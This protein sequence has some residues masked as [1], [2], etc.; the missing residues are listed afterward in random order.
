LQY[1]SLVLLSTIRLFLLTKVNNLES[2]IEKGHKLLASC[3]KNAANEVRWLTTNRR[4]NTLDNLPSPDKHDFW[5]LFEEIDNYRNEDSTPDAIKT[6]LSKY[7]TIFSNAYFDK[8]GKRKRRTT[9]DRGENKGQLQELEV[10][11]IDDEVR[12]TEIRPTLEKSNSI[13]QWQREENISSP[14]DAA[15][16]IVAINERTTNN[17]Q[18]NAILAHRFADQLKVRQQS[19]PCDYQGLTTFEMQ[20]FVE[21]CLKQT[22]CTIAEVLLCSITFGKTTKQLDI[23]LAD[24]TANE[25]IRLTKDYF[26]YQVFHKLPS[27]TLSADKDFMLHDV[28]H[29]FAI[30]CPRFGSNNTE[31]SISNDVVYR[32]FISQF[33]KSKGT[34]ITLGRI[35]RYKKEWLTQQGNDDTLIALLHN[36]AVSA[37]SGLSYSRFNIAELQSVHESFINHL[38]QQTPQAQLTLADNR[39]IGTRLAINDSVLSAGL[40]L[41]SGNIINLSKISIYHPLLHTEYTSYI[42]YML[43]LTTGYRP[44]NGIFGTINDFDLITGTIWISDK[45]SRQGLAARI[46]YLPKQAIQQ[47]EYYQ[48]YLQTLLS[49]YRYEKPT[50][51]Q[52]CQQ[53][54]SGEGNLLFGRYSNDQDYQTTLDL[55]QNEIHK[56][57]AVKQAQ[58]YVTDMIEISPKYISEQTDRILPL[59]NNWNRHYMRNKLIEYG[60]KPALV[61]TWMGHEPI[62]AEGF[63]RYSG[64]SI[65]DLKAIATTIETVFD[66]L[67]IYAIN[68]VD[69]K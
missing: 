31:L 10:D 13:A 63:G 62:G 22:D 23:L 17:N 67:E 44:V 35:A 6:S 2:F 53:A 46:L 26:A 24:P 8:P 27:S 32:A 25:H 68:V 21:H 51:A 52:R 28:E 42:Q 69:G 18:L 11:S 43:A 55:S 45:E 57:F 5:S 58:D 16:Y 65:A 19:A 39:A 29:H 60:V 9:V 33:N 14:P 59:P 38:L 41:L 7:H 4:P 15:R 34:R 54:L 40:K 61:D 1:K 47:I 3:V 66:R 20:Q 49:R 30:E 12:V 64:F 50:L 56:V 36:S 37:N 48:G